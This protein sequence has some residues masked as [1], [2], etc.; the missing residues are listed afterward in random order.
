M[1]A[2]SLGDAVTPDF[3]TLRLEGE[4]NSDALERLRRFHAEHCPHCTRVNTHR[5]LVFGEGDPEASL[6]FV[7][8][9][10]GET[11]DELGRPFVGRAGQKLDEMI[12]AMGLERDSV[13]IA[14][15]L[16]A[17][18]PNNR[19]P[20]PDEVMRCGPTL[21]RQLAII[22][23]TAIVAL[24]A[25]STKFLLG[26]SEGITRIR[27]VWARLTLPE[28][29]GGGEIEVM[30]TFHPAYLLRNYTV[31]TRKAVWS[32]LQHVMRRLELPTPNTGG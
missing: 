4:S 20:L 3:P 24:G 13:Y 9:A 10:P 7:G 6:V 12:A 18:P 8:E 22:R 21:L 16:K 5:N 30:P 1:V 15:I 14:N 26:T 25:P 29:I 11:E 28:E 17:R 19:T 32:D 27:G 23:P 2:L 31:E